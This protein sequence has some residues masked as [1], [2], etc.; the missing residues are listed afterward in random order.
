MS[1]ETRDGLTASVSD[2]PVLDWATRE[3]PD[4]WPDALTSRRVREL[5]QA[6][7]RVLRGPHGRVTLPDSM[8]GAEGVPRYALQEFHNLPNGNYSKHVTH[9]YSKG[10]DIAMLGVMAS[11]RRAIAE[12]LADCACVLDLGCGG[13]HTAGALLERGSAEVWGLDPSPYLLQHAA[14][15]YPDVR[16]VQGVAEETKF[17][18]ERFD[19]LSACFF[20]HELPPRAT[21]RALAECHRILKPGGK[22]VITDPSREQW[23]TSALRLLWRHGWRGVYFYALAR[24]AYE[25]FLAGFHRCDLAGLLARRGFTKICEEDDFPTLQWTAVRD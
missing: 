10:F 18:D 12:A 4:A 23:Q 20:F 21:E 22:L 1:G 24:M 11:R 6:A 9:G 5:C 16:F 19:G 25:P 3:L 14:R 15:A 7:V 17:P 13:G 2:P 8:T